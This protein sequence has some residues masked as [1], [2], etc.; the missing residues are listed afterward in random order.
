MP[1]WSRRRFL[2]HAAA[3]A[4]SLTLPVPVL[5]RSSSS[6]GAVRVEGRVVSRG[7]GISGVAVTDGRTVV[8][9]D[10]D[11]RFRFEADA[12]QPFVY[13]SVP[14]GYRLP[15]HDTGTLQTY[16]PLR[17]SQDSQSVRFE[18]TPLE[19]SD[20]RHAFVLVADPQTQTP[21]EMQR[22]HDETVPDVQSTVDALGNR[23]VF[24]VGCGD[25]MYDDLSLFPEYERAVQRM[26][27]P[28]AQV[29]GNHD[30]DFSAGTDFGS[31]TTFR[32]HFGPTYYS[33]DRGDVHY[34]V[35]DD[36][37]WP[38]DDGHGS[39]TDDYIGYVDAHQMEWLEQDLAGVEAG[40]PVVV[41]AHIPLEG[42]AWKRMGR[43]R[44]TPRGAVTNRSHLYRLL[45]P[46]DVHVIGGHVHENEH[47]YEAGR[48][49]H[50]VGTACGA[51]WTG[52]ICYD[53]TP[54]GYAVYE[55]DGTSVRWR[56]QSTGQPADVQMRL[57]PRGADPS[58]PT[59]MVANVWDA[60]PRWRVEWI[61]DGQRKGPMA[62]R[63]GTDPLAEELYR[64]DD[65]PEKRTWIDPIPTGHLYYA[66]VSDDA[67]TV[68]VEATDP[69]GRTYTETLKE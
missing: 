30:L 69:F 14:S 65:V 51:W 41:F 15:Q 56:Y 45:E 32:S 4:G 2:K 33:L 19:R 26:G 1:D 50:V 38:G 67:S 16:V 62:R 46:Y 40:R 43:K 37:F 12:R 34:V 59:E 49:H 23:P 11:G 47:F 31:V 25:L 13:V 61:V 39:G 48:H 55:V 68:R 24:G 66:P 9:T 27:I 6:A 58:A 42:T 28:F 10:A 63:V 64:G 29:V 53:G 57:Y 18:L 22:F 3:L 8:R 52:P 20:D 35:L 7:R 21:S 17:G 5:G 54:S 44:P 60:D 36:V